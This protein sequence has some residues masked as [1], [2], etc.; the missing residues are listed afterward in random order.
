MS[1][2]GQGEESPSLHLELRGSPE[3]RWGFLV[4]AK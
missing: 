3:A 1:R 2:A 4:G